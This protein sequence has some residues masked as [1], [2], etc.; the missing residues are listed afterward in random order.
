[1]EH[2]MTKEEI[3]IQ[4]AK[5]DDLEK[6][7][8]TAAYKKYVQLCKDDE[9]Y[10]AANWLRSEM[11]NDQI[12]YSTAK[13]IRNDLAKLLEFM[14]NEKCEDQ[15]LL[16]NACG[17]YITKYVL[18]DVKN[19]PEQ[20][21]RYMT[22]NNLYLPRN[23]ISG[24][25]V[26]NLSEKELLLLREENNANQKIAHKEATTS[27]RDIFTSMITLE[28]A[29]INLIEDL[30]SCFKESSRLEHRWNHVLVATKNR[31]LGFDSLSYYY[32][33]NS[34]K[35]IGYDVVCRWLNLHYDFNAKR[36]SIRPVPKN[37]INRADD[38]YWNSREE[39]FKAGYDYST[40]AGEPS[41]YD[42]QVKAWTD[43]GLSANGGR[44]IW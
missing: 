27:R 32:S 35:D 33:K 2:I 25:D 14:N 16:T 26:T 29:I 37:K 19:Q 13:Q 1:M 24:R 15:S 44:T 8:D 9:R 12:Y 31:I 38:N 34:E 22:W 7:N 42:C 20:A 36:L 18:R 40:E 43:A 10:Y 17:F 5:L 23:S 21:W 41:A 3:L 30:D 6:I 39:D 11:Q 4:R 28:V